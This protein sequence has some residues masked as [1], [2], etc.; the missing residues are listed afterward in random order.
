MK[1]MQRLSNT[2]DDRKKV[3][4][5]TRLLAPLVLAL[6]LFGFVGFTNSGLASA[7]AAATCGNQVRA[8]G[9]FFEYSHGISDGTLNLVQDT[10]TGLFHAEVVCT[11]PSASVDFF[12]LVIVTPGHSNEYN[13]VIQTCSKV[14]QAIETTPLA[15]QKSVY[16]CAWGFG[17]NPAD[18]DGGNSNACITHK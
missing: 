16:F 18:G 17:S 2:G 15:Y 12:L 8:S 13:E 14:G 9:D 3:A 1:I 4:Q 10:C 5:V 6:M 7:H 11:L